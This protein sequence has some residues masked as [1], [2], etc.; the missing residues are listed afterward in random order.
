MSNPL[1]DP[2]YFCECGCTRINGAC[3][4]CETRCEL[5]AEVIKLA[6]AFIDGPCHF[7]PESDFTNCANRALDR[8][9][10]SPRFN[11]MVLGLTN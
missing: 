10:K 3:Y 4:D 2:R 5:C 8:A 7:C 1:F 11:A 9:R 6:D